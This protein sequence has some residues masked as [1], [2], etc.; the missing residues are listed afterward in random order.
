M[1]VRVYLDNCCFNRPFDD[2]LNLIVRLE[3][4]AKTHVQR[5]IRN[6]DIELAWSFVLDYENAA[7]P[8]EDRKNAIVHWKR[9]AVID[10][11][12]DKEVLCRAL[13][14]MKCGIR[15]KDALHI[16]CAIQG[17][18]QY[19]LTTDKHILKKRIEGITLLNP[20]DYV[21]KAEGGK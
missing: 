2:P 8:Y 20:L 12:A 14:I 6:G 1:K 5:E 17:Q 4:E 19:F 10:I 13:P 7:N 21:R 16:A 3:A 15:D 18:C 11:D 9:L